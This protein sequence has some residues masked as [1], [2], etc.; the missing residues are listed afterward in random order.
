MQDFITD[1]TE[2]AEYAYLPDLARLEWLYEQAYYARED[3]ALISGHWQ[4]SMRTSTASCRFV[5]R[6]RLRH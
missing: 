4:R 2:L 3:A 5:G 1:H 6:H